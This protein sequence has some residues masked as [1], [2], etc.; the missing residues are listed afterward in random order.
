MDID[1]GNLQVMGVEWN[2]LTI[3]NCYVVCG[4]VEVRYKGQKQRVWVKGWR[5]IGEEQIYETF[6]RCERS[7]NIYFYSYLESCRK[8]GTVIILRQFDQ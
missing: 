1:E 3:S 7:Q 4:T 8:G 5:R 6:V 2:I